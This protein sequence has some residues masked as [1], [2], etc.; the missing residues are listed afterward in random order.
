MPPLATINGVPQGQNANSHRHAT[1][2]TWN[3]LQ[4][5]LQGRS[6]VTLDGES[7][8]ISDVIAVAQ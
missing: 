3:R 8:T 4:N 6:K 7:L 1:E 2:L 5:L